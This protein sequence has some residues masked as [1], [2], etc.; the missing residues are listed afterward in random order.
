MYSITS[1]VISLNW[2]WLLSIKA[3]SATV[4]Y[5]SCFIC[6]LAA[7]CLCFKA[8]FCSSV[9][10][11]LFKNSSFL[12]LSPKLL[13]LSTTSKLI[14]LSLLILFILRCVNARLSELLA[15]FFSSSCDMYGCEEK[16]SCIFL[17]GT[18]WS[19][20]AW[21]PATLFFLRLSGSFLYR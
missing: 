11:L 20:S 18:I 10:D 4:L 2:V 9:S 1:P 16:S 21:H 19:A 17:S 13:I 3:F 6:L 14:D 7:L 8:F 5:T 12:F 15:I